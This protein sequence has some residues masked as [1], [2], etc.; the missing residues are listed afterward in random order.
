M[1]TEQN[2]QGFLGFRNGYTLKMNDDLKSLNF[3]HLTDLVVT[4]DME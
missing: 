4:A 3:G 1:Q 2:I